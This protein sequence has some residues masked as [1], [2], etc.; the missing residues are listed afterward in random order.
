M[1]K[2]KRLSRAFLGSYIVWVFGAVLFGFLL[3]KQGGALPVIAFVVAGLDLAAIITARVIFKSHYHVFFI[4]SVIAFSVLTLYCIG[5]LVT[6]IIY[7]LDGKPAIYA[8]IIS[9]ASLLLCALVD[10]QYITAILK[11]HHRRLVEEGIIEEKE[12]EI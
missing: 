1:K 9:I 4:L 8:W 7:T 10:C 6:E 2:N 5:G 11:I 12:E 3:I